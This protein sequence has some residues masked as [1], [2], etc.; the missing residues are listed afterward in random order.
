M[1]SVLSL[2]RCPLG[3]LGTLYCRPPPDVAFIIHYCHFLFVCL[4]LSLSLSLSV[5]IV[6]RLPWCPVTSNP[7]SYTLPLTP[8]YHHASTPSLRVHWVEYHP[9]F[10]H[11]LPYSRLFEQHHDPRRGC[12]GFQ[13][14]PECSRHGFFAQLHDNQ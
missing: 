8:T 11:H 12:Q 1:H 3:A 4:V 7:P 13:L 2:P 14:L 10:E 9:S 6:F 5:S